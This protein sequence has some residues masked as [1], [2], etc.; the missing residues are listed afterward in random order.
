MTPEEA[1]EFD[2]KHPLGTML[3]MGARKTPSAKTQSSAESGA[4]IPRNP[5]VTP[6]DG[7]PPSN[8]PPSQEEIEADDRLCEAAY[9][10]VMEHCQPKT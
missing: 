9:R 7:T 5:Y 3:I 1:A 6:P 8:R 10:Y 2:R 4:P